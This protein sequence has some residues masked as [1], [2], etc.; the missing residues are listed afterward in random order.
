MSAPIT[1]EKIGDEPPTRPAP[2]PAPPA[3]KQ[4]AKRTFPRGI[5]KKTAKVH[6]VR[7]PAKPSMKRG[8]HRHT[9]RMMT[10][11]GWKR[12]KRTIK[13][14]LSK[15]SDQ[16]VRQLVQSAGLVKHADTPPAI[17]RQIL[18]SASGAGFVSI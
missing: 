18:E 17:A 1:I 7:D 16:S 12:H 5:L 2:T 11:K 13:H 8:M 14:K 15:M 4:G 10:D 6:G 9:I 3:P